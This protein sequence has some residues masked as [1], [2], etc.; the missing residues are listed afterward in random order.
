MNQKIRSNAQ[1]LIAYAAVM[2]VLIFGVLYTNH[3]QRQ[4][5]Q[6]FCTVVTLVVSAYDSNPPPTT[7]LGLELEQDYR[8]LQ[9]QLGCN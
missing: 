1:T 8:D 4:S 3:V 7:Q 5:E 9:R 2:L 6:K